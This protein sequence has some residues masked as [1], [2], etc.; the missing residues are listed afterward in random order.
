M[1]KRIANI[2]IGLLI[3]WILLATAL[4]LLIQYATVHVE[5]QSFVTALTWVNISS[6]LVVTG[7]MV[8]LKRKLLR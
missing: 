1:K 3:T 5:A 4:L 7:V 2:R 6:A 8:W